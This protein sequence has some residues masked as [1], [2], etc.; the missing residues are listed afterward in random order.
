MNQLLEIKEKMIHVY[1]K[2]GIILIPVLKFLMGFL[3]FTMLNAYMGYDSRFT[4]TEVTLLLALFCAFVPVS[5]MVLLLAILTLIHVY[6][7]AKILAIIVALIFLVLYLMF[8]R[9]S[10]KQ[11]YAIMA[12]PMLFPINMGYLVPLLLGMTAS[13]LSIVSACCGVF[14]YYFLIIVR[15]TAQI[16]VNNSVEDI[17]ALYRYVIDGILGNKEMFLTMVIFSLVILVTYFIRRMKYDHAFGIAITSGTMVMIL[18]FLFGNIKIALESGVVN[19]L[20]GCIL[21]S[22]L[23]VIIQ[24]IRLT[25]DYTA[26]ERT[27]F[28]D[29]DYYYYVKAVPKIRV[30]AQEKNVVTISSAREEKDTGR[31]GAFRE[32]E[33][34]DLQLE[35]FELEE[36]VGNKKLAASI[37]KIQK[38]TYVKNGVNSIDSG[39]STTTGRTLAGKYKSGS[40]SGRTGDLTERSA[41]GKYGGTSSSVRTGDLTERSAAG[42]YRSGSSSG[43]TGDLT[44]RISTGKYRDA[45]STGR[46]AA[47]AGRTTSAAGR[48]AA[49][50]GNYTRAADA[51]KRTVNAAGKT[52]AN[53]ENTRK[54]YWGTSDRR[55]VDEEL[56]NLTSFTDDI[57]DF[58]PIE[59][60]KRHTS[61][62][63]RYGKK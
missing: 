34:D 6:C 36:T 26:V 33:P 35:A 22:L 30:T 8:A 9:L 19:M 44:E 12:I 28:E 59:I 5:V 24:F 56:K 13:P 27:Q 55:R 4:T 45:S 21:S 11:G 18:G 43:R 54:T 41:A 10:P 61:Y 42:K 53:T 32:N 17:L 37:E 62:T 20:V 63:G 23:M 3:V 1:Q 38:S 25:L 29:D 60:E 50:A 48:T 15:E 2:A 46:T 16:S 52:A 57:N 7:V 58:N 51:G 47:A 49:S 31:A 40:S 14:V 39:S